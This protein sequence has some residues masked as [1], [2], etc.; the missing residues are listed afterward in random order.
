[1]GIFDFLK[2]LG[3]EEDEEETIIES[4]EFAEIEGWIEKKKKESE[5][6]EKEIVDELKQKI[7]IFGEEIIEK[8]EVLR[9]VDI[10]S[11]KEIEKIKNIVREGRIK[12]IENVELLIDR[13]GNLEENKLKIFSERVNK[14][15]SDFGKNSAKS[16]E[17]TTILIGKEAASIRESLKAFSKEVL[18]IFDEAKPVL[19][20]LNKLSFFESRLEEINSVNNSLKKVKDNILDISRKV[21]VKEEE[22]KKLKERVEEIKK[23]PDYLEKLESREKIKD[24]KDKVEE[25]VLGLKQ[26]LDFK[27]LGSFFHVNPGQMQI[28]KAHKE[29]FYE[30]FMKDSGTALVSLLNES[31]LGSSLIGEKV[32]MINSDLREVEELEESGKV[33]ESQGI[34]P[35]LRE[36]ILEIEGLGSLKTREEK[37]AE[38]LESGRGDL[39]EGLKR[40]LAGVGVEVV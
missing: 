37:K 22:K 13:L 5:S 3:S 27:A 11:K 10:D 2:N 39:V 38:K 23:S 19:D 7:E 24:L 6:R 15:F 8:I 26:L 18:K 30:Q 33:D 9:N 40:E 31:K 28:V 25:E 4:V 36:N 12:Y 14:F 32:K 34:Y 16:Y 35:K 20:S 29:D 17:I 1:M 21:K